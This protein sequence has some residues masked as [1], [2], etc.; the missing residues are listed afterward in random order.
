MPLF[1]DVT[2]HHWACF[3]CEVRYHVSDRPVSAVILTVRVTSSALLLLSQCTAYALVWSRSCQWALLSLSDS[4]EKSWNPFCCP[5][6]WCVSSPYAE[7]QLSAFHE[8]LHTGIEVFSP[9]PLLQGNEDICNITVTFFRHKSFV[10]SNFWS[11]IPPVASS[12]PDHDSG[13]L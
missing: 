2:L 6:A 9:R 12:K 1:N 10:S 8:L 3:V 7:L 13:Y 5:A 4:S 11:S